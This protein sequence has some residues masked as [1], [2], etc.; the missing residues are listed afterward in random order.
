[1]AEE[2]KEEKPLFYQ[3]VEDISAIREGLERLEKQGISTGLMIVYISD[4]TKIG[5]TKIKEVLE[6]QKDFLRE[7]Q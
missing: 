6:A 1:M 2:E 7:I 4:K 5:K 3:L